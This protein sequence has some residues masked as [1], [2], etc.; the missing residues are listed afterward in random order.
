LYP[1][2][3]PDG[4]KLAFV[5]Y[6]NKIAKIFIMNSDGSERTVIELKNISGINPIWSPLS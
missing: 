6:V 3:S 2:W 4:S 5:S 1:T